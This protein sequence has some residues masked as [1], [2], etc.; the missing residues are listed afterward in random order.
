MYV[1][2]NC[3]MYIYMVTDQK[4]QCSCEHSEPQINASYFMKHF[5][6]YLRHD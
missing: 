6:Q 1:H 2:I 3:N 5:L 4:M